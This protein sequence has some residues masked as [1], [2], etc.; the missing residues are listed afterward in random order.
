MTLFTTD[1]LEYYLT[2][3][4]WVIHNGIWAVL[5][6][7]GVFA[8]PFVAIIIQEWLR[9]RAEGSSANLSEYGQADMASAACRFAQ[10]PPGNEIDPGATLFTRMLSFA[11]CPASPPREL[12]R[13]NRLAV[14]AIA[15]ALFHFVR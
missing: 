4:S 11:S 13:M 12:T 15:R 14:A 7:S 8:I 3:L 9:A 1:Y 10:D 5:V 2:L 6:S